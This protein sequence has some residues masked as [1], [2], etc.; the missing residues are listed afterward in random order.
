MVTVSLFSPPEFLFCGYLGCWDK[1]CGYRLEC[2]WPLIR[3]P[4]VDQRRGPRPLTRS[5]AGRRCRGGAGVGRDPVVGQVGRRAGRG[6]RPGPAAQCGAGGG[7]GRCGRRG[8]RPRPRQ[9]HGCTTGRPGTGSPTPAD[10]TAARANAGWSEPEPL[11]GPLGRTRQGLVDGTVSPG[12]ADIIVRPSRTCR[13]V[14][15]SGGGGRRSCSAKPASLDASELARA[16]RHLAAVVDPDTVD[17][18]LE[19]A[20][21]REERAA[22]LTRY[23]SI[24]PDRAGGVRVRGR[25]SAE[26]GA[27]L[28]A[29][30]LPLT[31]PDPATK[32]DTDPETGRRSTA[33]PATTAPACGTPSSPPP[34]TPWTPPLPP[35]THGTPARLLVTLDH[36]TLK[37]DLEAAGVST[38]SG[39]PPTAPTYPPTSSA[40][41]PVTPRSSPPSSAPT[42]RSSTSAASAA[43]SPP[44]C[45]PR[46]WSATDTAPSPPADDHR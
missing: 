4:Y 39:P 3:Y 13:P 31:C 38:G 12:Q 6:G 24:S 22:H 26:D 16:G 27:L 2:R 20:L 18:R 41:S 29:A 19:A 28:M 25:G 45:G 44:P 33:T 42:A 36:D 14:T 46:W 32:P 5:G 1:R 30:L 40:G 21:E 15:W 9:G 11:T 35:E 17:R 34:S 23:L 37:N 43:W 8:R 10:S 7:R